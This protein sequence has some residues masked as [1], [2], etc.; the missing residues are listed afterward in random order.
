VISN[1]LYQ[2]SGQSQEI[3]YGNGVRTT[4]SY[5]PRLRLNSLQTVSQPSTLNSQLISFT[6][7][8]DGASNLKDILDQ[9][10]VSAVPSGDPRRNTQLFGYDDLY[11]LTYAGYA[12]D[13]PGATNVDGGAIQYRYDRIDD[14]LCQTSGMTNLDSLTGLPVANLGVMASGGSAGTSGRVGRQPTDPSGPHALSSIENRQ[15]QI[16]NRQY[17][18]D[19]NGNMTVIDGLTNTWDFK[20]RLVSVEST[21]MRAVYT[22]D[23]TDRRIS[24]LVLTKTNGIAPPAPTL[25]TLYA[26]RYFEVRENDT[27]TKYAWNGATRV[28]RMTG[29][30]T[31]SP[32]VQRL[33]LYPGQNLVSLTVTATN[34]LSQLSSSCSQSIQA[35]VWNSSIGNWQLAIGNP[36][37]PAGTVL[38]LN[39]STNAVLE[40]VGIAAPTPNAAI[41]AGASFQ[42]AA[43]LS[44]NS[45][46]SDTLV[47]TFDPVA[48][49]WQTRFPAPL[50]DQSSPSKAF[51]PSEAVFVRAGSP[52]PLT[53]NS[54]T[55]TIRYYHQDHL[56]SSSVLTDGTSS[57]FEEVAYLPFGQPRN[58]FESTGVR[59]NYLFTEKEQD[60]ESGLNYFEARFQLPSLG[61]FASVDPL[62]GSL[63]AGWLREPQKLDLYAYGK[64]NP[65]LYRDPSGKDGRYAT[66]LA[67]VE[68]P[69]AVAAA[70]GAVGSRAELIRAAG[71][72]ET[73]IVPANQERAIVPYWPARRGFAHEP[74]EENLPPGAIV[75]RRGSPQGTFVAPQ[76]TPASALSL[77]PGAGTLPEQSYRVMGSI[78]A[79]AGR[80][81][82]AF[83]QPGGGQQYELH[84][85]VQSLINKGVLRRLNSN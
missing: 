50:Q 59:E 16:E 40:I 29:S 39:A 83:G 2:P 76:G 15:S 21:N 12:F 47:A 64:N 30:S 61:R 85:S 82:P 14:M 78:P 25:T 81:A 84:N 66:L 4:Y 49:T 52:V 41:P 55:S 7:D 3:D 18:Y 36:T 54:L 65:L 38:W 63:P 19:A 17:P 70:Q 71:N 35:Y 44:A 11:R 51:A 32:L 45:L 24:K 31:N 26:D 34:F 77:S 79:A 57:S 43:G 72:K 20:D 28:A 68:R 37:L 53:T 42:P 69:E 5:D 8:F 9:R 80:A 1:I 58:D 56:G 33:R 27:P 46:P 22:Y 62:S 60:A 6:Y 48:K 73:A 67:A 10:P 13:A 74:E 23:Y 75:G